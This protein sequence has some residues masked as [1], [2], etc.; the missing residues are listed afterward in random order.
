MGFGS[1]RH[2]YS[3][4]DTEHHHSPPKCHPISDSN[5]YS[6]ANSYSHA[7]GYSYSHSYSNAQ[8]DAF[9]KASRDSATA[10]V[11]RLEIVL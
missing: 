5:S 6:N 1:I 4:T 2:A 7:N 8:A 9:A 11:A 10:A 3:V